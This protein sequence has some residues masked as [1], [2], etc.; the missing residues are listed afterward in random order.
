MFCIIIG[1]ITVLVV[2]VSVLVC[3][4]VLSLL[5]PLTGDLDLSLLPVNIIICANNYTICPNHTVLSMHLPFSSFDFCYS[6]GISDIKCFITDE[7]IIVNLIQ[8]TQF[9]S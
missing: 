9:K 2:L 4:M 3:S 1:V 6:Y 8:C 7:E 5:F